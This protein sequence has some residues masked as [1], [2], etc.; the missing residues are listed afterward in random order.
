MGRSRVL[1]SEADLRF[2]RREWVIQR[3]GWVAVAL[4]LA[5]A[6]T[7]LLGGGPLSHAR[8]DGPAGSVEYE[9]FVRSGASS[10]LVVTPAHAG[11]SGVHRVEITAEF[12][13]AFRIERITPEPA[14]VR[15]TGER[16]VYE[17]AAAAPGAS[18]SFDIHPQR[19]WRHRAAVRIDG[20]EPLE[21]SQL[22]YP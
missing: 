16:L 22:T 7:G 20:G 12:L 17:F 8:A 14:S 4:F 5:A 11:P 13:A 18:I 3:I 15:M 6:F 1:D 9:R 2:H 19:L 10:D 21:I